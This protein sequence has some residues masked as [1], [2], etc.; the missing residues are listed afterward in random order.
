VHRVSVDRHPVGAVVVA[1]G[2]LDAYAEEDLVGVFEETAR[3]DRVVVDLSAVSFL[4]STALGILVRSLRAVD[5][6]G[7]A[8]RVVLPHGT[9]RRIFE[10]TTLDRMLPVA[11]TLDAALSELDGV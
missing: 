4:D 5:A 6:R 8:A 11:E 10:L 1:S 7:G 2:E 3:E 9:A